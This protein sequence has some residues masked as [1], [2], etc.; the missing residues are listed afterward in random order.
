M[1]EVKFPP[2]WLMMQGNTEIL[3]ILISVFAIV[4]LG[5]IHIFNRIQRRQIDS[6]SES[7][8][9]LGRLIDWLLIIA[10]TSLLVYLIK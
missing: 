1:K 9:H 5:T 3:L 2:F 6:T 8:I 7:E 10:A 4:F